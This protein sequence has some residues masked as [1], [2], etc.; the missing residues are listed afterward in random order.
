M[1]I[2]DVRAY[3]DRRP[4]NIRHSTKSVDLDPLGYS[5]D[6]TDRKHFVEPHIP[7][8]AEFDA[9]RDKWIL[10]LGCG[11]GTAAIE[12]T[13]GGA[14]VMA[15]DISRESISIAKRRA[16][17]EC[18]IRPSMFVDGD[19]ENGCVVGQ[20][21]HESFDLIYSFGAIHH[22]PRPWR[23]IQTAWRYCKPGG[24]FRL[25][26]YNRWSWKALW[27]LAKFGKFQFWKW[28]ELIARHSEAQTGCPITHTYTKR[29]AKRLLEDNGFVVERMKVDHIFP[30]RIPEYIEHR[31]VKEWYWEKM[32]DRMFRWL[33]KHFGWH[34]LIKARKPIC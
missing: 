2:G 18:A 29:S 10:E 22:T 11:I 21:N 12:F 13:K 27:I 9:W 8:F 25:M 31:Y 14:S 34:L 30:Y 16:I 19:I 33:E 24:E 15:V 20:L 3:W 28:N 4:C 1:T 7:G 6:V 5:R 32:P 17:A 23:A 26:L